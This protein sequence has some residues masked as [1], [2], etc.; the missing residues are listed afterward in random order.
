MKEGGFP[1]P[2]QVQ[3][4]PTHTIETQDTTAV[5]CLTHYRDTRHYW[6]L[7]GSVAGSVTSGRRAGRPSGQRCATLLCCASWTSCASA[8]I[9]S[10]HTNPHPFIPLFLDLMLAVTI[11]CSHSFIY[12]GSTYIF[13]QCPSLPLLSECTP[14]L[15][16]LSDQLGR[17]GHAIAFEIILTDQGSPDQGSGPIMEED[18]TR[19]DPIHH[20]FFCLYLSC[21]DQRTRNRDLTAMRLGV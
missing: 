19:P 7:P 18:R 20:D 5:G 3:R 13:V 8:S 6:R 2:S 15:P 21:H 12:P 10:I 17:I 11:P 1:R 4:L 9:A 16:L 14:S